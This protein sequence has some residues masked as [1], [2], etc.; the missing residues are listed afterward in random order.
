ML[1]GRKLAHLYGRRLDSLNHHE[2]FTYLFA[3]ED[4]VEGRR[5]PTRLALGPRLLP[6]VAH[7]LA[8]P[9]PPLGAVRGL[10]T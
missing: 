8:Y 6:V 7:P 2:W 3:H 4:N 9:H 5:R 1:Q 10:A